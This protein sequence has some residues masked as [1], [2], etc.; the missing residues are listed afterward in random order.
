MTLNVAS[1]ENSESRPFLPRLEH[2]GRT[3][4]G[5]CL[6]KV[7]WIFQMSAAGCRTGQRLRK[8]LSGRY[9]VGN[10]PHREVLGESL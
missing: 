3:D 9:S 7:F 1:P 5:L 10:P 8:A 6:Q 4:G 2:V